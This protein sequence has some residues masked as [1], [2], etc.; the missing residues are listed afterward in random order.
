[1]HHGLQLI[2]A[3]DY[4]HYPVPPAPSTI[5]GRLPPEMVKTRLVVVL[6]ARHANACVV[7]P[8]STTWDATAEKRGFHVPI[9]AG[10]FPPIQAWGDCYRWAKCDTIQMVSN[11]R[12]ARVVTA[13]GHAPVH[14]PPAWVTEIQKG[15]IRV[16]GGGAMFL[17]TS[18]GVADYLA[19]SATGASGI[20][21]SPKS[22]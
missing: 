21:A 16:I 3:C 14:L 7:V 15:V 11:Q 13:R 17:P 9:P 20:D 5:D 1:M 12:L 6:N 18:S 19:L 4:G 2:L 22:P 8:L 10:T